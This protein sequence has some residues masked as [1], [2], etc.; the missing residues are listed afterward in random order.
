M[1]PKAMVSGED[2][3]KAA[4]Q[5]TRE[6]GFNYVNARSIAK[7]LNCSTHPIF[8]VYENMSELKKDLFDYIEKYY[9]HFIES[10]MSDTNLFLSIGMAYIRFARREGNLF[11]MMFMSH[12]FELNDLIELIDGEDNRDII[13]AISSASAI[14]EERAKELYLDVW[15]YTHGIASMISTNNIKLTD[16]QIEKML[17]EVYAALKKK[18]TL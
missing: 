3:V 12:N 11:R 6:Y 10:Q 5:L 14:D 1:P 9:N 15:L 13:R 8:R 7:E 2:I 4:F 16:E 17:K 18:E